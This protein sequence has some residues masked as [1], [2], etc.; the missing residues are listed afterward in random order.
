MLPQ[1]KTLY[2]LFGRIPDRKEPPY[3]YIELVRGISPHTPAE[4]EKAYYERARVEVGGYVLTGGDVLIW[5]EQGR[6][7]VCL[8]GRD[9]FERQEPT[10]EQRC[11]LMV[12]WMEC[13]LDMPLQS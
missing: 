6:P 1:D 2:L 12:I 4:I 5:Y 10:H 11:A 7:V 8:V 13:Q 9:A 3:S